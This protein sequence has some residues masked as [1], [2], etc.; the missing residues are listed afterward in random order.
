MTTLSDLR[1]AP[2]DQSYKDIVLGGAQCL[3]GVDP[4]QDRRDATFNQ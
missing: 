1:G 3:R 2:A 4:V